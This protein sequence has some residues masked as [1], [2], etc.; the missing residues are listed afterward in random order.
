MIQAWSGLRGWKKN[1]LYPPHRTS[2]MMLKATTSDFEGGGSRLKLETSSEG[3]FIYAP[4]LLSRGQQ[5]GRN[6]V[7]SPSSCFVFPLFFPKNI[8][9]RLLC[10]STRISANASERTKGFYLFFLSLSLSAGRVRWW[11]FDAAWVRVFCSWWVVPRANCFRGESSWARW[12]KWELAGSLLMRMVSHPACQVGS[13]KQHSRRLRRRNLDH[14]GEKK[15]WIITC[16]MLNST[17]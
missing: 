4:Q 9:D 14:R 15:K 10:R 6:N 17:L 5:A 16:G 1:E 7:P 11:S 12:M 2:K 8:H 13:V 3:L